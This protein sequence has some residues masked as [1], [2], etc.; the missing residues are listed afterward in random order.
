MNSNV[1]LGKIMQLLSLDDKSVVELAFARLADGTLLESPTFDVGEKVEV[2]GEDGVKTPA[3]DGEHELTLRD[4]EGNETT[5]KIF[6]EGGVITERENV[7]LQAETKQVE[8]LPQTTDED[9]AN[10]VEFEEEEVEAKEEDEEVMG[11]DELAKKLDEMAYRLEEVEK[12]LEEAEMPEEEMEEEEEDDALTGAPVE[13]SARKS[14]GS[15]NPN[16]KM[17]M[18][19]RVLAKLYK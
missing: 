3:P 5:F 14:F 7:E 17:S 11:M 15:K 2:V 6:T 19:E 16:A 10:K 13:M 8:P 1:V 4:E 18:Q 12:K 9:E